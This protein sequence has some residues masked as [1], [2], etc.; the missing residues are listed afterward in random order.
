MKSKVAVLKSNPEDIIPD[1]ERLIDL[2]GGLTEFNNQNTTIIKSNISWHYHFA[3]ANTTPWQLEGTIKWLK[4]NNFKELTAVENNTVVTN[5]F[6]GEKLNK[7][8]PVFNK[9]KIPI[10]Y[11]FKKE[12]ITWTLFHPKAEMTVLDKLFPEGIPI[13]DY[14]FNKNIVHLPTVKC[15][16]Y[17]QTTGAIKNAFGG[18]LN[19]KR[20]YTHSQ[21]HETL[22]DLLKIQQ[23]IHS[24][25]FA[26]MD[27]T[28]CG[29]GPGPRTM[30]PVDKDYMLA[31]ADQVAIDAVAA[32]MMGFDPLKIKYIRLAHEAG[33][34]CGDVN[35]IEVVGEDISNVNFHFVVGQ[36]V[37]GF[38][39][40][41]FW[42]T[43]LKV[44]QKL[45]FHTPLLYFF[46][47]GSYL[48]HDYLWWPTIGKA[49]MKK[50]YKESKW[51]QLFKKY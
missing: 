19:T 27:G 23:E 34:G 40:H 49:R 41:L 20:H 25:I 48:Y 24:G 18:L 29:N 38:F 31:S 6:K 36:N 5:P 2:G 44:I 28:T 11:N 26:V 16:I 47:F 46:V 45:L 30:I 14:F 37:T 22:V 12:D 3:G 17:T 39:G 33:L 43:P 13:P 4:K 7:F 15:H 1:I 51:A 42:F 50:Y 10:K 21:I 8:T 32:K 9:Y 35:E